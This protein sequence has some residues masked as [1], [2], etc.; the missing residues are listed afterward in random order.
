MNVEGQR[1]FRNKSSMIRFYIVILIIL[2][3]TVIPF[4]YVVSASF[5]SE[6]SIKTGT[7]SLIPHEW[8]IQNYIN[9][10][11][12]KEGSTAFALYLW[13]SIKVSFG[14]C[15]LSMV[16][17]VIA[18]YGLSRFEF[19]GRELLAQLM[20]FLY[21]FPTILAI[22][23]IY[24]ILAKMKLINTHIGLIL[25]HTT[26]VAPFCTWLLR[27]FFDAIPKEI[28]ESAKVDGAGRILIILK[29]LVPLAAP[30]MLAAGMYSLI[31]SWGEYM[32]ASILIDSG[33][34]KTIPVALA[35]YMNHID[36]K[37]GLLLAGCSLNFV[38]LLIFFFPFLKTF[39]R[40]FM[41]GAVKA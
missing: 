10:L 35:T 11:S 6:W 32:F 27:S 5:Q 38:P 34:L 15:I 23:P 12:N 3:V 22:F 21:V 1:A 29:I 7:T 4:V 33:T 25:V 2:F 26:L 8:T 40:G 17:S 24:N 28:E 18:A 19:A 20:L 37:W 14:T 9:I 13:N 30:G 36:Q 39:L 41:A 16:V 31:Y